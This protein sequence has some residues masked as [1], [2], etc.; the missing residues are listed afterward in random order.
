MAVR[1]VQRLVPDD[2]S[3]CYSISVVADKAENRHLLLST[4]RRGG[5]ILPSVQ[6]W[7]NAQE[8]K[9]EVASH[10]GLADAE[11]RSIR[12]L[13]RRRQTDPKARDAELRITAIAAGRL[14]CPPCEDEML[15]EGIAPASRTWREWQ[16]TQGGHAPPPA[17]PDPRASRAARETQN[18]H[19]RRKQGPKK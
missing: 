14:I 10:P 3:E 19:D 5:N 8:E 4:S 16:R 18:W 7:I 9:I 6:A 1:Q 17:G 13:E 11:V 12:H 15:A 2:S